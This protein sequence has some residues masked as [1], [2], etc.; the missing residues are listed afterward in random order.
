MSSLVSSMPL[1][2][3]QLQQWCQV[4]ESSRGAAVHGSRDCCRR[5]EV[6]GMGSPPPA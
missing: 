1:G 3:V 6:Q 4:C 5:T 2:S